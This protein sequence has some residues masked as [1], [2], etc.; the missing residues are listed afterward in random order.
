MRTVYISDLDGTLLGK[1]A[2]LSDFSRGALQ[3]LLQEGLLFTVASARSVVSIRTMLERV[4]LSLPVIEF[5]GAFLSDLESGRHHV[6]HR[7]E[8]AV[9][10][11]VYRLIRRFHCVPIVS[12][13]N[14]SEDCAYYSEVIN[15]GMQWY[16]DDRTKV[17]DPRL[18]FIA[19]LTHAFRDQIV[20]L[21]VIGQ[22]EALS[23]LE[24]A[25]QEGYGRSVE[26]HLYESQYSPGWHW[27]T[28]HDFRAT[29]D[30]AIRTL[31]ERCGLTDCERVAF[32]DHDND[33]KMFQMADRGIAVANA[34]KR[35]R[36]HATRVI[37]PNDEDS[38]V[39]FIRE[40]VT[41]HR[42]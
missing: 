24:R 5:N 27:L 29:K 8:P 36:R 35:L 17:R 11:G 12:S 18:R 25:I 7:I 40:E 30:R 39:K 22:E 14:G 15:A 13:F 9:V 23:D 16:L 31:V 32:G 4:K 10:E 6:I 21:T 20:C 2:R 42:V 28:V 41:R 1:D 33:I 26:T 19:D 34:T 37:G 38:V 3:E